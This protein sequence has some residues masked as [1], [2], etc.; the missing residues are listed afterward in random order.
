M[1]ATKLFLGLLQVGQFK[2]DMHP[3]IHASI[4]SLPAHLHTYVDTDR[5]AYQGIQTYI[6]HIGKGFR[7][8]TRLLS[9]RLNLQVSSLHLLSA[10]VHPLLLDL[11]RRC[12]CETQGDDGVDGVRPDKAPWFKG[13]KWCHISWNEHGSIIHMPYFHSIWL[14]RTG[15]SDET[16]SP[17]RCLQVRHQIL[18]WKMQ[19]FEAPSKMV[20]KMQKCWEETH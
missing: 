19:W 13:N 6:L 7:V 17:R 9:S 18:I 1:R 3:S 14:F 2:K 16:R 4:Q 8:P 20:W 12:R 10:P 15:G 5:Q 11:H